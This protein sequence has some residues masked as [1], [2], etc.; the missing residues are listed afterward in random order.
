MKQ[1]ERG[2]RPGLVV[3]SSVVFVSL[4]AIGCTMPEVRLA[5]RLAAQGQWDEAVA[6]YRQAAKKDPFNSTIQQRLAHAKGRAAEQH[7][8]AGRQAL[9]ETRLPE[10]LQEFKLALGLDPSRNEHHAAMND[11]LRLKE[12][13]ERL[14]SARKLQGLGRLEEALEAYERSV[15]LDPS[16]VQ[17]VEG[18]TAVT[19]QQRAAKA[20]GGSGQP[21]TLRFQNAKLKEVFEILARAGG[22]NVLFDKDVKD[23]PITIFIKDT[24]FDEALNMILSLN[25]LFARRIGPETLLIIPNTKPKQDQY[26]DLMIRTFYLSNAKAKD[27]VNLLRTMLESK[28]VYVNEPLNA[29]VIRDQPAKLQLA[30]RIILANDRREAEV[31]LELEVLEVNR[32]KSQKLGVNFAKSAGF[33]VVPPAFE[34]HGDAGGTVVSIA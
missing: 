13:Q 1:L 3:L 19:Q 26:Q 15:E 32:T 27:M 9:Q 28:R 17:A 29:V 18:I 23:D 21:L 34:C 6:A 31:E 16:L 2:R 12:A 7:Y 4:V 22:I 5:D 20:L 24:P 14:Q 8:A 10:A 30:E 25:A 11:A 33:G